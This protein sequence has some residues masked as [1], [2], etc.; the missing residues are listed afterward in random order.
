MSRILVVDDDPDVVVACRIVL[1]REGYTVEA[2]SNAEEGLRAVESLAPDLLVLDVMMEEPDDG[3]R[4]ARELR[5]K[6]FDFPILMLTSV[7]QAM[8][9]SID[10]D[11]DIVP[12]DEFLE[13]PADP[14]TLVRMV[15]TL[16]E[17][18]GGE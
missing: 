7:N 16:L 6:G 3:L 1:E 12:V 4:L 14:V 8:G 11:E 2:A 15:A 13:K 18:R 10:K 5:R 17:K 9:L